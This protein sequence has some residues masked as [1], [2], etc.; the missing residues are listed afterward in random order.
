MTTSKLFQYEAIDRRMRENHKIESSVKTVLGFCFFESEQE[1]KNSSK[2]Q[3]F[4]TLFFFFNLNFCTKTMRVHGWQLFPGRLTST[5]PA[6]YTSH[7]TLVFYGIAS[8]G[9]YGSYNHP[10]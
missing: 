7:F 1:S 4:L 10:V 3:L 8:A 6:L 2:M 5:R 9:P